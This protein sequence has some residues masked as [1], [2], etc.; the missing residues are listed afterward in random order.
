MAR[1]PHPDSNILGVALKHPDGSFA[2]LRWGGTAFSYSPALQRLR[3]ADQRALSTRRSELA[4]YWPHGRMWDMWR[5][6]KGPLAPV[7]ADG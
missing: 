2:S 5:T 7:P 4:H 1:I 3:E 6:L